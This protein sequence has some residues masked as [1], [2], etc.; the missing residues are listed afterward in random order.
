MSI[1]FVRRAARLGLL[2]SV[3]LIAQAGC[4]GPAGPQ[5]PQGPPGA[6]S[7]GGPPYVWVCTPA[8]YNSGGSTPGD[9][10]IFNGGAA[11]ANVAVHFLNKDGTNLSGVNVPGTNPA[12]TY[13][14]QTGAT[15][16]AVAPLNTL[17][18]NFQT[19]QGNPAT[20]GNVLA[21]V[22]VISDQPV[23]VGSNIQFS[24]FHPVPCS[25]LPK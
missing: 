10:S 23:A 16:V 19:A 9:L 15:T 21:S 2:A 14:G 3:V 18:V 6:S 11:A 20:G 1:T 8:N 24:G 4:Q 25:P 7:G 5:G 12:A 13:P 17:I 22:R